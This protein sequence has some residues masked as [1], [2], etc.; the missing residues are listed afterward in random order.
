[1]TRKIK[2]IARSVLPPVALDVYRM[3]FQRTGFFGN[4]Q[5]WE[6]ARNASV[7]YNSEIILNK[8]KDALLKVKNGEAVY[9]RDS[10]LFDKVE[11]SWPLLAG[12]L[13]IASKKGNKLSI[14]DFGGSLG[15]SYFQN[16]YFLEH[17]SD[18]SWNVIEQKNFV[19]CG[20]RY[21]DDGKLKFYYCLEDCMKE[22]EPHV[23]LLSSV[24]QYLED[25][26]TVL[27]GIIDKK[28]EL[29]ILDRT[30]VLEDQEDRIT[31]QRVPET[32]YPGSY[33]AWFFSRRKL[34]DCFAR[35][36]DLIAEFDALDGKVNLRGAKAFDKGFIFKLKNAGA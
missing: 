19:E 12:L 5:T 36:Y 29:I 34:L 7:G 11:Y 32:I 35:T 4:Y 13:W 16:K 28:I 17:I 10:V 30:L 31:V 26:Y 22:Q 14:V 3:F 15:S 33:P 27:S 18:L 20:K 21:F 8:V 1:M 23:I 9:E 6:E 25:P 2:D 24:I